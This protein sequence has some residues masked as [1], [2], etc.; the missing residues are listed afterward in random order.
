MPI[1]SRPAL[2]LVIGLGYGSSA[3]AVD[4]PRPTVTVNVPR[5]TI[6]I[7][8][9]TI[10]VPRPTINVPT[11]N[12]ARPTVNL[13][14]PTVPTASVPHPSSGVPHP[15]ATVP[16]PTDSTPQ[17]KVSQPKVGVGM[18]PG[19]TKTIDG[20]KSEKTID[21]GKSAKTVN[22]SKS[23]KTTDDGK[24]AK[25]VNDSKSAKTTDDSKSAKTVNDSKSAKTTDDS[26]SAKTVNESKSAK[27]TDDSKSAKTVN[28]KSAKT[29]DDSKSATVSDS[30]SAAAKAALVPAG[31]T[32]ASGSQSSSSGS[33]K[34]PLKA[35]TASTSNPSASGPPP[36]ACNGCTHTDS[37][38]GTS[39][40]HDQGNGN[41]TLTGTNGTQ[42][43]A[44]FHQENGVWVGNITEPGY[45]GPAYYNSSGVLVPGTPPSSSVASSAPTAIPSISGQPTLLPPLTARD[46][47]QNLNSN[48][49]YGIVAPSQL[50][51]PN[52]PQMR[53]A[54]GNDKP[55]YEPD[56]DL[57]FAQ[58]VKDTVTKDPGVAAN[59]TLCFPI[60]EGAGASWGAN[61]GGQDRI[62][63]GG[64]LL[65][66]G[67]LE[68]STDIGDT[69]PKGLVV[70]AGA[71]LGS[72]TY[73]S[74]DKGWSLK[75][76]IGIEGVA[77]ISPQYSSEKGPALGIGPVEFNSEGV[78]V[79]RE[80]K[81][82][83]GAAVMYSDT[84]EKMIGPPANANPS[85]GSQATTAVQP[86]AP[87]AL[88][89]PPVSNNGTPYYLDA[90]P[91]PLPYSTNQYTLSSQNNAPIPYVG[92]LK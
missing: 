48:P 22:D 10:N 86:T 19:T 91:P 32:Q 89:N 51:D 26:K 82:V 31:N 17:L 45:T 76:S 78:K 41:W 53:A 46:V 84:S 73:N 64:G 35:A 40:W 80:V 65:V 92:P 21:D 74:N 12:V 79:G 34:A 1:F 57:A 7:P 54:T 16:H 37:S 28:D 30:K 11:V 25:T 5:P 81:I 71:A 62:T 59:G 58:S 44:T 77:D 14:R 47:L 63:T 39:V 15:T 61:S 8:R 20:S 87:G 27:T 83:V 60:C 36:G 9:P 29:V 2:L 23:A 50:D 70:Q 75:G 90:N 55:Y 24:S 49:D 88:I 85:S 69:L 43:S 72:V 6:N 3:G 56:P 52:V 67:S 68:A 13:S 38:G 4:V 66:N 18:L 42:G 33:S